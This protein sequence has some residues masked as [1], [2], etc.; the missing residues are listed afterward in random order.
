MKVPMSPTELQTFE[1]ASTELNRTCMLWALPAKQPQNEMMIFLDGEFYLNR[2]RTL[3]IL[4]ELQQQQIIPETSLL[5]VSQGSP[6]LRQREFVCNPGYNQFLVNEVIP[7][8]VDQD[9]C[10]TTG[11]RLIGLS[12]SALAA[13]YAGLEHPDTFP[14]IISQSPSAWWNDEWLAGQIQESSNSLP[15]VRI[16]V[17]DLEIHENVDHGGLFQKTSQLA[18]CRQ[19]ATVLKDSGAECLLSEF[20][21]DHRMECWEAELADAIAWAWN[22]K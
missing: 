18:S 21:G 2:I 13:V 11:H 7:F 6:E 1:I 12:L 16:S 17:G 20:N 5:F 14:R 3:E 4:R 9:W 22:Q 8:T 10:G 15:A 19:L